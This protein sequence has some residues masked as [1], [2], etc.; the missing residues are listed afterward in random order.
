MQQP[1]A[2]AAPAAGTVTLLPPNK[3]GPTGTAQVVQQ[4]TDV[5]ITIHALQDQTTAAIMTGKCTDS[6]KPSVSG[7]AQAL[8]PLVNGS[9]ET[10][11]ANTTVAQLA[12]S[13]H[14]I[15]VQGGSAPT[16][17]GDVSTLG[18]AAPAAPPH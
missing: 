1:A 12:S 7:P 8:K 10:T 11:I 6:V 2:P 14:V 5:V 9:S 13:P 4:G 16:L 18:A 15:V 17:C 3:Q